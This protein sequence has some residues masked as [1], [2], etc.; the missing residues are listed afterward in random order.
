[1]SNPTLAFKSALLASDEAADLVIAEAERIVSGV[2]AFEGDGI[3]T[4]IVSVT[5]VV[6]EVDDI[7]EPGAY[8][9]TLRK[10]LPKVCWH[11]SW[12]HPIGKVLKIEELMPGDNRLPKTTRDGQPWPAEAGALVAKM[13]MNMDSERGR[14]AYSAIVFYSKSGECEYSIGYKVPAGKSTRDAKGIR[15]I[16]VMDLFELSFVLFGAHTMTGTL[17]LKAA[18]AVMTKATTGLVT[19]SKKAID[20]EFNRLMADVDID[21]GLDDEDAI[22]PDGAEPAT[23]GPDDQEVLDIGD[24]EDDEEAALHRSAMDDPEFEL[25]HDAAKSSGGGF[26]VGWFRTAGKA[27]GGA[28][29]NRGGAENLR[30]A[31]LHGKIA[32]LIGWGTEGDFMRCVGI[33]G[34]HMTDEQAKGYCA[35]RHKDATDEWPGAGRDHSGGKGLLVPLT[36]EGVVLAPA[37]TAVAP[38]TPERGDLG[39]VVFPAA[40][41]LAG[42]GPTDVLRVG[43]RF[44][45]MGADAVPLSAE[46]VDLK[47]LG[48]W[49]VGQFVGQVVRGNVLSPQTVDAAVAVTS[50]GASPQQ[51]GAKVGSTARHVAFYGSSSKS[52]SGAGELATVLVRDRLGQVGILAVTE[53]PVAVAGAKA[54]QAAGRTAA[55]DAAEA[56]DGI[57]AKGS[58]SGGVAVPLPPAVVAVAEATGNDRAPYATVYATAVPIHLVHDSKG[59]ATMRVY[60]ATRPEGKA[61]AYDQPD[62][63]APDKDAPDQPDKDPKHT[64]VMVALY[65]DAEAAKKIAVRGGEDAEDLHVTLAFLGDS[66]DQAGDG[67]TL[68]AATSKIVA[69]AQVAAA[70]HEPLSGTVGGIGKFPDGGDGVPVIGLVDVVGLGAVREDLVTALIDAGLPVKVDHG[71]T[72]HMTLGYNLDLS[73]IPDY[74]PVPVDFTDLVVCVG[75]THTRIPLGDDLGAEASGAPIAG[76][77][78]P[79]EQMSGVAMTKGGYDPMIETGPDAGHKGAVP[80]PGGK[81]FPRLPGTLEERTQALSRALEEALLSNLDEET[82][83]KRYLNIDGTWM[84]RVICTVNHWGP[85][86]GECESYEFPY[87]ITDDATVTL[88][89]PTPVTLKLTAEVEGAEIDDVPVGDLL[90]MAELIEQATSLLKSLGVTEVKAGRVLSGNNASRLKSVVETLIA[91]LRSAGIDIV[92]PA[93]EDPGSPTVDI[94]TT[95][96]SARGKSLPTPAQVKA[97]LDDIDAIT[98]T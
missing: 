26:Q 61:A 90:P 19:I 8:A 39:L 53:Q 69:A 57:G 4:A 62:T 56:N 70:T 38:A 73:L 43:D 37:G 75:G 81:S 41:D 67:L 16:K 50:D 14:E 52:A 13:Q 72:P 23:V 17:M 22:A 92:T 10:R 71:F 34:K 86:D 6:D 87:T 55:L 88:G 78:M 96:P 24:D 20:D 63:T 64:G 93:E 74:E 89:E 79:G 32:A 68:E 82:R 77:P 9:E 98:A 59:I 60:G 65:P 31:Y 36:S 85:G 94:E 66:S 97:L 1:M 21:D 27:E 51:A 84:D 40:E 7:I 29:Q 44:Q 49:A 33:A 2:E 46:V 83:E 48:D 18:V 80:A 12:D 11:H 28:D 15:R 5:G 54:V 95:A 30:H 35:N 3:V 76:A 25:H 45:V 47:A 91:V 42:Q 58:A